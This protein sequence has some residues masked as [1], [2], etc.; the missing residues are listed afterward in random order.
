MTAKNELKLSIIIPVYNTGT[1]LIRCIKS[2]LDQSI[3]DIELI[4]VDDGSTDESP[5]ICDEFAKQYSRVKVIHKVNEGVSVAR[6]TGIQAAEGEYIGFVD[7]DDWIDSNMYEELYK[8]AIGNAADIVM[9]DATTKYDAM[10]DEADTIDVIQNDI[11]VFDK[12]QIKPELLLVMAGAAW[13][14]IYRSAI[15]RNNNILFPHGIKLAEDRIFNI[16]AFGNMNKLVYTKKSY[17]NRYV[18]KGSAVNRYYADMLD[19]ILM[20]RAGVMNALDTAWNSDKAYKNMYEHQILDHSMAAINNE[21]Y[22]DAKGGFLHR[23]NNIK[24]LCNVQEVRNAIMVLNR[25]DLRSKLIMHK[26]A[27]PLCVLAKYLNIKHGR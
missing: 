27:L 16:L 6:N 19:V 10:P 23:Y 7:S 5:Q 9:C 26:M 21:F 11:T 8:L 3:K 15:L 17:Y 13:R 2:I 25:N 4:I 14:C 12:K 18:R 24:K 1:E 20:A 22:K